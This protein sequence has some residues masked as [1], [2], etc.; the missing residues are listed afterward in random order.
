[1]LRAALAVVLA[2]AACAP[3]HAQWT[4]RYPRVPGYSHHVYLE[5]FD[6]PTMAA[7]PT[8]PAPSP[9]GRS[10]VVAARGWL[11]EV[12]LETRRARRITDGPAVDARPAWSPDG[13][14]LAFV[15][16]DGQETWIVVLDVDAGLE[17]VVAQAP[18][19]ELDPAF[20]ADG[21]ALVYAAANARGIGLVRLDLATGT[22]QTVT[23][24]AGLALAPR[25][26]PDGRHLV[27]L[28]KRGA[29]QV[30]L[31][32]LA[33]GDETVLYDGRI[34]SQ[35]RPALAPDGQT[36]ALGLP[37][38]DGWELVVA[39]VADPGPSL[40]LVAGP[41]PPLAPA[42]SPDGDW[43][44]YAQADAAERLRLMRVPTEGGPA[45]E[46][47][48]SAWDWGV[49]LGTV[50]IRTAID[51]AP[52]P[53][54]LA[55]TDAAG[56]PLLPDTGRAWFD[57][58]NGAVYVY[59][60]G[61]ITVSAPAGDVRVAA[62][63]GL[64][65]PVVTA[66]TTVEAGGA[67]TVTLGLEPVWDAAGWLSGDQHFHLNYGGPYALDPTDLDPML[68]GEALDVAT[69]LVANLHNRYVDDEVWGQ[70]QT[71]AL[72][73]R[74]FG[75]EVRS[76]FFGHVGLVGTETLFN[77]WIWGPGYEV[78]GLDD[79]ENAVALAHARAEGGIGTYVHPVSV[80]DPFAAPGAVPVS[81]VADGVL[82]DLDGIEVVCLWT[83]DVGTSELWYRLLNLGRVVVPMAGSDVMSNFYRTMAPGT[84]RAFVRAGPDAT[85]GDYLDGLKAGRSVVTTGPMLDVQIGGAEPGGV[86]S[87]GREVMWTAELSSA[88]PVDRV[89]VVVNGRVVETETGLAAPGRRLYRGTIEVPRAGWVAIRAVGDASQGWPTMAAY[90]FAHTAPVWLGA[91]GSVDPAA[92]RQAARD[93]LR[94]LDVSES[95][96]QTAYDG[97]E[98][99]RLRA[100][101]ARARAELDRLAA[102]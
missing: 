27:Y 50:T 77:P 30:R 61:E 94:V 88:V 7:G 40:R 69:P 91:V 54:R 70:D 92:E 6:L 14:R 36:L 72:P 56:H 99:P 85:Y 15:R 26:H 37:L 53:A 35:T 21:Q 63:Q 66:Q 48:V 28:A 46:V 8:D 87:G 82:G 83:D 17:R 4:N 78:F 49:G 96:F 100:R 42:F 39:A 23:E 57:G 58:E 59:S 80:R 24:A 29:E 43:V 13:A 3:A 10:V 41:A 81:L 90:P 31:R 64:A 9:D 65:T 98:A 18:G 19:L 79:R 62:V 73:Y 74:A 33:T 34:L 12:D 102:D 75:Q 55:I 97:V 45:Q 1:M 95:R 44:Y 22:L 16:D 76:H 52:A 93:L 71:A 86:V 2:A 25:P 101:F 51:G 5:G 84:A 60:P 20:T 67:A 47:E 68:A 32:D 11:W 89:E 38:D